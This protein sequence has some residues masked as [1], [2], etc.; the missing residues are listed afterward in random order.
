MTPLSVVR[1]TVVAEVTRLWT[2]LEYSKVQ[3]FR[4]R[5]SGTLVLARRLTK[6]RLLAGRFIERQVA[7]TDL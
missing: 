5:I 6:F 1:I 4:L 3:R 2:S 7:V